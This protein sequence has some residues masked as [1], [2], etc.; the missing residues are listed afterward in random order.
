[1]LIGI[2]NFGI[3]AQLEKS[4]IVARANCGTLACLRIEQQGTAFHANKLRILHIEILRD[5]VVV[6]A[7][8]VTGGEHQPLRHKG[9]GT[10]RVSRTVAEQNTYD[11]FILRRYLPTKNEVRR[12]N[13]LLPN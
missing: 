8:A 10:D 13:S 5:P 4:E 9:T 1:M 3:L 11:V 7:A 2:I 12:L 6:S